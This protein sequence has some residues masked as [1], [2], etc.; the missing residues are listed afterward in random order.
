M[1]EFTQLLMDYKGDSKLISEYIL[2]MYSQDWES[3]WYST[4]TKNNAFLAFAKYIEIY[5][6]NSV[7]T[8]AATLNESRAQVTLGEET[9]S[10]KKEIALSEVLKDTK[11]ALSVENISGGTLFASANIKSYPLDALKVPSFSDGVTLTRK[12]YEV[13]DSSNITET[14]N[15]NNGN[16]TCKEAAG[17]KLHT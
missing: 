4:K 10:Y 17:L 2:K 9:N 16:R 12:I 7:N 1:G 5:G 6:K 11:V 3:Y 14:C 8:L 13:L 15:W